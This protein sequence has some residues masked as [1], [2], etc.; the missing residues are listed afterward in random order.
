M[1][2]IVRKIAEWALGDDTGMSSQTLARAVLEMPLSR[3]A[4]P[5]DAGDF[6][7]C[8]RLVESVPEA[9]A[10]VDALAAVCPRWKRLAARWD[11]ISA[12]YKE[13]MAAGVK[14]EWGGTSC[15]RTY[16][17]VRSLTQ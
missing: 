2:E 15:P 17:L 5:H 8:Y 16:E 3:V 14:N 10:G 9:R 13:E 1:S 11:E 12:T 6:G 4:Y 7:R